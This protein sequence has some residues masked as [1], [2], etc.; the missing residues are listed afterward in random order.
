MPPYQGDYSYDALHDYMKKAESILSERSNKLTMSKDKMVGKLVRQQ[1]KEQFLEVK[2]NNFNIKLE[3]FVTG[4]D[5]K[6]MIE[7]IDDWIVPRTGI[8]YLTPHNK[9]GRAPF[10]S[11]EK[12]LGDWH[13]KTLWFNMAVLLAMAFVTIFLLLTDCPGRFMRKEQ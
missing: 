7:V 3:E 4:A 9:V 2:R 13:V 5:S 8:I 10:Y 12:L 1:G 11:S 6:C